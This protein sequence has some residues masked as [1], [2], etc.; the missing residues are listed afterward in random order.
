MENATFHQ[1]TG[2]HGENRQSREN[3]GANVQSKER[4]SEEHQVVNH[5]TFDSHAANN[6]GTNKTL[7]ALKHMDM[8]SLNNE[9]DG[10]VMKSYVSDY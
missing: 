3:H 8:I 6:Q 1:L 9:D 4:Q 10:N 2:S 7:P 5:Q